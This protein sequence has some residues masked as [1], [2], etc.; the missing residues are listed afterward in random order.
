MTTPSAAGTPPATLL[1]S[2]V[3]GNFKAWDKTP[4]A[5]RETFDH[6]FWT[7]QHL[8]FLQWMTGRK[9]LDIYAN[10]PTRC[11]CLQAIDEEDLYESAVYLED[12]SLKKKQERQ[13][14]VIEW[15]KYADAM[16]KEIELDPR[17]TA[18]RTFLLPGTSTALICSNACARI[19]GFGRSTWTTVRKAFETK[20]PPTHGLTGKESNRAKNTGYDALLREFFDRL[21]EMATPR[22]TLEVRELVGDKV[23]V[24]L[25]ESDTEKKELPPYMTKLGLYKQLSKECNQELVFN[26]RNKVV[27]KIRKRDAKQCPDWHTFRSFWEKEYS[28]IVIPKPREDICG[29]CHKFANLHKSLLYKQQEEEQQKKRKA[30]VLE[31]EDGNDN[32][33]TTSI[34]SITEEDG[35]KSETVAL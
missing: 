34:P 12:F 3:G 32:S 4:K 21:E 24:S 14:L 17:R 10:R 2:P 30:S 16:K 18:S 26:N 27:E 33:T 28:H 1:V 8:A 23:N 5:E 31:E 25:K 13:Q 7:D 19:I 20:Q 35:K 22:A 29:D 11:S 6:T 15:M 9:C